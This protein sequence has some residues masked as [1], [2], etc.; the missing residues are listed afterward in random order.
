MSPPSEMYEIG[1]MWLAVSIHGRSN[2]FNKFRRLI[3]SRKLYFL[4]LITVPYSKNCTNKQYK[5]K[6]LQVNTKLI[7]KINFTS[8]HIKALV[9]ITTKQTEET[10]NLIPAIDFWTKIKLK[11][12]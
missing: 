6:T 10:N 5:T 2:S 9:N 11:E 3:T 12:S 1:R 7:N 4:F 8:S